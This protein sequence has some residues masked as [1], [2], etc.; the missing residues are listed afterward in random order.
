LSGLAPGAG[1]ERLPYRWVLFGAMCVVYFAFGVILLAI[2]P[3]VEEV[4]A[5]LD[6]S[7]GM[8][9][10]ALGAWALLY[11]VTAPPAGQII[12][13]L[14]LRRSL[15]AGSLLIAVSAATQAAAQ[16][17]VMLWLA[18]GII[19][20]GGPLVS[21]SAPKLVAVWF[22]NPRER[23]LAV[24][25][26]TSAPAL[27]GV[28]ALLLTNSVLLPVLGDWRS[29]L[30]FEATLILLAALVWVLVSS[31]GPS[32]PVSADPTEVPTLRGF[33]A[34]KALLGSTG[35]RLAVLLG[36]GT[37]FITQG[38]SAWLPNMLEEHTGLSAGAASNWAAASLAVGI[39][40]RLVMPGLTR[41][42]RRSLTLHALMV[43]LGLAMVVMA[44]G[45]PSTDLAAALVLGLRSALTSLVILVLMECEQVTTAN[46]GLAYGL[47]FS[48][49]QIGGALGP[50]VV[51][52]FGD[53]DVGFPGA[54]VAMAILL[55][56]MMTV[57]FR[58][59]R[60]HTVAEP[61][62]W[63]GSDGL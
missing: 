17:V 44:V 53:A 50:P 31:H 20:I 23:A 51:G 7:R 38:L 12:D 5:E 30:L 56:V 40:A 60:R 9:G 2:P 54:L 15:T 32:E 3:M 37:F 14:G 13:R 62:I 42:E 22:S 10:F 52:A 47:W 25:F 27:G 55:V 57:L 33:E 21:L 4:R 45:P 61:L 8:L 35:V 59:D 63:R 41:P 11:I 6:I 29:V 49:G 39:M 46:V 26:Y 18:I 24:G 1:A 48:A 19:G 34:A 16:G 43:A 36:I 28:F 58:S